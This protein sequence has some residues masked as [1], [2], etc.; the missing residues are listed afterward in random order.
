[1]LQPTWTAPAKINADRPIRLTL[2]VSDGLTSH[3]ASV[4]ITVKSNATPTIT[5][6]TNDAPLVDG[7]PTIG[8]GLEV[9]LRAT[10]TDD[11]ADNT[12]TYAWTATNPVGTDTGTFSPTDAATTTWTAPA[13]TNTEQAIALTLTVTDP[14]G[15]SG[16]RTVTIRVSPNR[17]PEIT[18]I[19]IDGADISYKLVAGG[20]SVALVATA[21]DPDD[22]DT[23][24]YAWSTNDGR[25]ADVAFDP[26]DAAT[27]TWTA[28]D[29]QNTA[30]AITLTL[31]VSDGG[32]AAIAT[33]NITVER[34][35]APTVEIDT[36]AQTVTVGT[37]VQ[38]AT[39]VTDE[40]TGSLEYNWQANGGTFSS[41]TIQN[42]TWTAPS[43]VTAR[44]SYTL[45]VIVTDNG[46]PNGLTHSDAVTITVRPDQEPPN[47]NNPPMLTIDTQPQTVG[48]GATVELEAT[49]TD[50]A[51][52][53]HTYAWTGRGDFDNA[54][55]EDTEWTAPARLGSAQS[56]VLRL[57]VTDSGGLEDTKTVTI[58]VS[59]NTI[60]NV[61]ITGD[62]QRKVDGNAQVQLFS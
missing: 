1:M 58:T 43:Q 8:G 59:G 24:E 36:P 56:I 9:E 28:P 35:E 17:T 50:D 41:G 2:T 22:G 5:G 44:T 18:G 62:R 13:K 37:V 38:L 12:L 39:T 11:D 49:V 29:A 7:V 30:Q 32:L 45:T 61:Q 47:P 54:A 55:A 10:V 25:A 60:P 20:D 23:L 16:K 21:T 19:T 40:D 53:T 52:D 3:T 14:G 6:I 51:G 34:N 48:G 15:L 42:P 57:T 26:E 4:V 46:K 33:V 27:T 31:R